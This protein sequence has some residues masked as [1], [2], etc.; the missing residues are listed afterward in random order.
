MMIAGTTLVVGV[1]GALVLRT[2]KV[3]I[4]RMK[5]LPR[6]SIN[7]TLPVTYE[8]H[9]NATKTQNVVAMDLSLGGMKLR[10]PDPMPEGTKVVLAL[11][12]R[13]IEASV[14]WSTT[15]YA[16][17]MFDERLSDNELSQILDAG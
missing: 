8:T 14:V 13:P 5:R 15:H 7:L 9:E 17:T 6:R 1:L 3:K 12:I 2:K 10:T 16:G 4:Y 11:S